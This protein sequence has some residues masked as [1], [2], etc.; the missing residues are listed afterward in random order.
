[1]S[2]LSVALTDGRSSFRPG[3]AISGSAAWSLEEAPESVELR[4]FWH[5]QGKGDE[6]V[7]IAESVVFE[8][9]GRQDKR[10]FK[11]RAPEGPYSFSGKLVSLLWAVEVVAEPGSLAG[12]AEITIS[13]TGEEVLLHAGP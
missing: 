11:L 13:P 3:E 1:M 10:E 2:H 7:G 4:L 8:A 9:P 6:D 12:R 5:T